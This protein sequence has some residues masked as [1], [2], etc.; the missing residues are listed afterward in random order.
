MSTEGTQDP[1]SVLNVV[2]LIPGTHDAVQVHRMLDGADIAHTSARDVDE[3]LARA[4]T[5][6]GP[7]V[8]TVDGIADRIDD[9][10]AALEAQPDWSDVPLILFA[11]GSRSLSA[12]LA[13]LV[14]RSGTTL[15]RSP[16]Q[17]TTF[18]T[19]VRSALAD[20]RRQFAVRSLLHDLERLNHHNQRRIH[21]LQRLT[22]QLSRV[23]ERERRR[24]A[25]LLHDDLQQLL[26]GAQYRLNVLSRRL[27]SGRDTGGQI[28]DLREQLAEAIERSRTLSHELSPP[29]L[30][31]QTLTEALRWL[32]NR[33]QHAHGLAV[34]VVGEVGGTLEPED[35]EILAYRAVQELL[36]NVVKHAETDRASIELSTDGSM[37]HVVVR[38]QGRGFITADPDDHRDNGSGF[39]L[40]SIS[41]RASVLGGELEVE[42]AP[43]EGCTCTL[44][45]PINPAVGDDPDEQRHR[46]H[47]DPRRIAGTERDRIKV[48]IVD[49]H[50]FLREG[51]KALLAEES[52]LEVIGEAEDGREALEAV[53]RVEP[54]V[55][56]LDV[57]MPVMDGIETARRL[58]QEH[59]RLRIIGLSTFSQD[60]MGERM[61]EAGADSYLSKSD[62]S[63]DLV[64]AVRGELNR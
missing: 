31:R 60:D 1:A 54:D 22:Y 17:S 61:R 43:G 62:P 34:E 39:G 63:A 24:L 48:L 21:Q 13:P 27:D 29:P 44:R 26:V 51:V 46:D 2:T 42:S 45:L 18:I 38:D 16:V 6:C 3:I 64:A 19:V 25:S 33:M 9:L 53:R 37:L 4:G 20:R 41:E 57:A 32:A 28:E 56:L 8:V 47:G 23:E 7:L 11:V 40:F 14:D 12:R 5:D 30:R 10:H 59:P 15:L 49:D 52:D 36:F 58:R 55:V 35:L 50:R